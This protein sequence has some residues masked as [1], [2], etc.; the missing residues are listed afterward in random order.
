MLPT[1]SEAKYNKEAQE[2]LKSRTAHHRAE[3][4]ERANRT[5]QA[6]IDTRERLAIT[7]A[8]AVFLVCNV[9]YRT[10]DS[11]LLVAVLSLVAPLADYYLPAP[12]S[13][14]H[15]IGEG[16]RDLGVSTDI[17]KALYAGLPV[18]SA[19]GTWSTRASGDITF[20]KHVLAESNIEAANACVYRAAAV[21]D[22]IAENIFVCRCLLAMGVALER[23]GG[24]EVGAERTQVLFAKLDNSLTPPLSSGPVTKTGNWKSQLQFKTSADEIDVHAH[25]EVRKAFA[26]STQSSQQQH[27]SLAA[28]LACAASFFALPLANSD[29]APYAA[30]L[31]ALLAHPESDASVKF[32][33]G[34]T[35]AVMESGLLD[36][37]I[38]ELPLVSS[39]AQK[40][41]LMVSGGPEFAKLYHEM[42]QI[43]KQFRKTDATSLKK[44][45]VTRF[46][47]DLAH[48]LFALLSYK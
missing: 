6:S 26:A 4:L 18:E 29:L 33:E 9:P 44:L 35:G 24:K 37:L 42:S 20:R 28:R 12:N 25:G 47:K 15:E 43:A 10:R 3:A 34:F 45:A 22:L 2:V 30:H 31:I 32:M 5:M 46:E 38:K 19:E 48:A 40:M 13:F 14:L 36:I 21:T 39:F 1:H 8:C 23:S 7:G 41:P 17:V 16:V 11:L 27:A